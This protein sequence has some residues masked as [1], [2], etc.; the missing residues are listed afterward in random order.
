MLLVSLCLGI[1]FL[2]LSGVFDSIALFYLFRFLL[3]ITIAGTMSVGWAFCAEMIS[4]RHRFKLRTFTSWTNGRIIM[5]V[6]T[7]LGRSTWRLAS[8]LNAAAAL[9][10]LSIIAFLPESPMWCKRK[11]KFEKERKANE[12]MDWIKGF[13]PKSNKSEGSEKEDKP[14]LKQPPPMTMMEL[15]QDSQ[16]RISFFTLVVMWFCAGLSTYSIDLNSE[17]QTKNLWVGQIVNAGLASI[18]RVLVGIAD[19]RL[20]WLGRRLVYI[21]SMG[22]CIFAAAALLYEN[23]NDMKGTH[24]YFATYLLAYNSISVSWETNYLSAAEL[25]PTEARAKVYGNTQHCNKNREHCCCSNGR[26]VQ[27]GVGKFKGHWEPGIMI[28]NL[29]SNIFSFINNSSL[30]SHKGE[31][32]NQKFLSPYVEKGSAEK[33]PGDAGKSKG[34]ETSKGSK[35]DAKK[36]EPESGKEEDK[37]GEGAEKKEPEEEVG[38]DEPSETSEEGEKFNVVSAATPKRQYDVARERQQGS[39]DEKKDSKD[40]PGG[41]KNEPKGSKDDSESPKEAPKQVEEKADAPK[42]GPQEKRAED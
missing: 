38:S 26:P 39:K 18:V 42:K 17:D 5:S 3:G 7:Y 28:Y 37:A 41:S 12:R 14:A 23:V 9:V 4:P 6:L 16:L 27:I 11:E 25:I 21:L 15:L 36:D 10:T 22:T 19:D 32:C 1:P 13:E 2:V 33:P 8:Y 31:F 35:E 40:E 24:L 29:C 20:L 30:F 34:T